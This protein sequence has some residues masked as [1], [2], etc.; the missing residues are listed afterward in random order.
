[1]SLD[2]LL[3]PIP[4]KPENRPCKVGVWAATLEEPYLSALTKLLA[5]PFASGGLSDEALTARLN[6]AG[7]TIGHSAVR[8]HRKGACH[9][10]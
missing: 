1:M 6:Q 2:A 5:T 9:C 3:E 10:G 7:F 4:D 8:R